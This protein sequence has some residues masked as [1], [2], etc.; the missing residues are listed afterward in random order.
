MALVREVE[1][2]DPPVYRLNERIIII[3]ALQGA[4]TRA[5]HARKS[6]IILPWMLRINGFSVESE[7]D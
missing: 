5:F 6:A 7:S 1:K 3:R 2:R 4:P